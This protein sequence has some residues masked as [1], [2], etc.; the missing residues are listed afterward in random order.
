MSA[1]AEKLRWEGAPL[2]AHDVKVASGCSG[3]LVALFALGG[4]V[5]S[6]E[7]PRS[8]YPWQVPLVAVGLGTVLV[9]LVIRERRSTR[10]RVTQGALYVESRRGTTRFLVPRDV[11]LLADESHGR[12]VFLGELP[13]ERRDPKGELLGRST[14]TFR[15]EGL[16]RDAE[17]VIRALDDAKTDELYPAE[18][19]REDKHTPKEVKKLVAGRAPLGLAEFLPLMPAEVPPG[20]ARA[21][22]GSVAR[23]CSVPVDY[24]RPDDTI[25]GLLA[26]RREYVDRTALVMDTAW[27]VPDGALDDETF[28]CLTVAEMATAITRAGGGP[29]AARPAP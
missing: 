24:L 20:L 15:L 7:P 2:Y 10:Y 18:V 26:R 19:L 4:L 13:F 28:R 17:A 21:V 5:I 25:D 27:F 22:R 6:L 9:A 12:S 3:I 16:G 8:S 1:P 29:R 23:A 14:R 11:T